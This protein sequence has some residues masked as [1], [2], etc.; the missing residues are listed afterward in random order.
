MK[1]ALF[2]TN[3]SKTT[4]YKFTFNLKSLSFCLVFLLLIT[5]QSF[6]QFGTWTKVATNAP[7]YNMGVMLLMTDG[8]VICKDDQGTNTGT[9]W[10]KLTPN[11]NGSYINGT[12]SS[13]ASMNRD[14]LFFPSQV[15][16][17]G[18]VFVA[19]GEYGAGATHGEVYDPVANTWT[20]TNAV[21]SNMNVYDG[22]S[23]ILPSGV[24]LVGLQSGI[25]PSFDCQFY[26][27]STNNWTTAPTA[28]LNHDEASWLKL[29]DSTIL[30]I[31]IHSTNSCRYVPKT[32]TWITDATVPTNIYDNY[33]FEAGAALLLPNGKGIFFGANGH[34]VIYTPS[35]TTAPGTWANAADFP[36]ISGNKTGQI[37]APAAMEPNGKILC[38][39]SPVNT[40]NADQF[41][42]PTWFVEYDYT[43]NT[44]AQVTS[45]IPG[46]GADSLAGIDCD[47][48]N[49]LLL[50]DGSVLMSIDQFSISNEYWIYTPVGSPIAAGIPTINSIYQT[51][52]G[53]YHIRGKLFNGIS[54]GTGF[55]DDWQMSTN[56]PI[57]RLTNGTNVYYA[58]TSYWNRVG[59]VRTD[60]LEDTAT[61]TLPA[62]LPAGTYSLV[63]IANGFPSKP[64]LFTTYGVS[65]SVTAQ[66]TCNG[67]TNGNATATVQ[68]GN[69]PYTYKWANSSSTVSTSNPTGPILSAGTYTLTIT[70]KIGCTTTATVTITQPTAVAVSIASHINSSCSTGGSATANAATGGSSPYTYVWSPSGGTNL[71]ASG[72]SAGTYTITATDNHGCTGTNTVIITS[73]STIRDSVASITYPACNGGSGSA[74]IGYKNG[75]APYTFTWSP[76][77]NSTASAS[78]LSAGTYTV[79][80]NDKNNC[81]NSVTF[82]MTQP[83]VIA[84]N[85]TVTANINCN[86]GNTG[87]AN[88][89]PTGGTTPYTY[90]WSG[91]GT[92]ATKTGLSAGTFTITVTDKN[93]C[94]ATSTVT[95]TQPTSL[96][97]LANTTANV[98][99]NGGAGGSVSSTP[100]GG[101]SPY[102]Y[103]WSGGGTNSTK[104]GL[105]AGTFTITVTDNKGCTATA[106]ATVTQPVSLTVT[107][108]V[109]AQEN[110]N[111]GANGSVSSTPA[112]G[113][114]PYTY[115]W[116]GGGTNS[117]KTALT[118]GTYTITVT[119]NHGCTATASATITQPVVLTVTAITTANAGCTTLGSVS[120]T[121]AGGT[122]P[123]T[124]LWT[125]GST[126]STETGL[127]AGTYTITV[128]DKNGC[129]ATASTVVTQ[130]AS[131]TVTANVTA[132]I[133]CNGGANGSVSSTPAGGTSPYTYAWS[134]GGTNA[135]KSG[136]T[137]G[138]YTITVTDN[139]GCIATASAT[140][141]QPA[142][143]TITANTTANINCNGGANGSVSSTPAG[144]TTPY[145]YA[146]SGGGTSATKTALTAGTYT[147]TV[148][149]N[150]G[151]TATASTVVTQPIQLTVTANTTANAGCSTLGSVSSTPAGGTSPYTY[152]WTGGST[153]S[154]ETGLTGGTYTITVTDNNGCAATAS[155]IITQSPAVTVTASV[156]ANVLCNGG[157]TG[158]VLST[159]ANGTAPY[160]YS[161]TGGGTNA[162]E[163][164]LSSGSYT[165]TVT[166]NSGC[167]ATASATITEPPVLSTSASVKS[168]VN[169]NGG[170]NGG[171]T[172][173]TSGGTSPYTYSWTGGGTNASETGLTAGS[174]TI[175]VTDNN[176][177]SATASS[178]IT[179][180]PSLGVLAGVTGYVSC[181]GGNNG[182]VTSTP[183]GGTSPYTY[184]WTGGGTNAAESGLTAGTYTITVTDINGCTAS[185]TATITEPVQIAVI[186]GVSNEVSC[187]GES[188]GVIAATPSGGT[189]PYT[190]AWTGGATTSSVS[191]LTIGNYTVTLTDNNGCTAT[192]STTVTQP[193]AITLIQG[194]ATASI[195][196]C[197][198]SAWVTP[199]GGT[200]P[201]TYLWTGGQTTDTITGQ[202]KGNYCCKV[203]DHNGCVDS[204]C[205]DILTGIQELSNAS[206]LNVYPDPNTGYFTI[207]GLLHGQIIEIYNYV[208]QKVSSANADNETMHFNISMYANGVYMIRI[209]NKDGSIVTQKKMVKTY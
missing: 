28:P 83:A 99:C 16:P 164:G 179:Q 11:I 47:Y 106:T 157:S 13:I 127:G 134:G 17:D 148:T 50:P 97:V 205:V 150:H 147:I 32:N 123:Y 116:S 74:T 135:T 188:N 117:T 112:G 167:T 94:S 182:G 192:S 56:Y 7:N 41:R 144:G 201:Y 202:C 152:A 187:F 39:V 177:C 130:S 124:Y 26:T 66:V 80:V 120:S 3:T 61:F 10:N 63:V 25:N 161:W 149:D 140:I 185:A 180:A 206:S 72:L 109:T 209:E 193:T 27:E 58:K 44:F 42:S 183:S 93:G 125:G 48:V 33:G 98:N 29:P 87:S 68:G 162:A 57:V 30:F 172:S 198:G 168:N 21:V 95:L 153:N 197:N 131:V 113:T 174:Y 207:T 165:I 77:S 23:M 15:L 173:S 4:R 126:T 43:T 155:T 108:S 8:T 160:T 128:T 19:G 75:T 121:P 156:T 101:T 73:A 78:G 2:L 132:N 151:C 170:N 91:G 105:T 166:D 141:T 69:S 204:I 59:A 46:L 55:G 145:T 51:T 5:Q 35:G 76:N 60:S 136:L 92:N 175:T 159:P 14:R 190:Y 96:T 158:S 34:N 37:D 146:W 79:I 70:D 12:W 107:A 52:C 138:T 142:L 171:V 191:G 86:G 208:G 181:N 184:S 88:S 38:A 103:A 139:K 115:A 203:T 200:S 111:G 195:G 90:A 114:S 45:T 110:C 9:G 1:A 64:T 129:A 100:A 196:N 154:T 71:T 119:D 22:N 199:S 163:S 104:T 81:P 137:A 189:T 178:I 118:A 194:S 143:L 62:G 82:T 133:N 40:S 89:T 169:C 53:S 20:N 102:T 6:A 84:A 49:F 176:G 18:K 65:A 186:A 122:S 36:T 54:E 67:G 24:V 31:G 85:A